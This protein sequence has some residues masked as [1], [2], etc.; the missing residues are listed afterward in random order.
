MQ[1]KYYL[2]LGVV[3]IILISG[4]VLV[5]NFSRIGAVPLSGWLFK[6]D[7]DQ[8]FFVDDFAYKNSSFD[9]LISTKLV[10]TE[11]Q[12]KEITDLSDIYPVTKALS[13]TA[14]EA[15]KIAEDYIKDVLLNEPEPYINSDSFNRSNDE[16]PTTLKTLGGDELE[17][18]KSVWKASQSCWKSITVGK[19]K[20]LLYGDNRKPLAW[21]V[22]VYKNDT[23]YGWLMTSDNSIGGGKTCCDGITKENAGCFMEESLYTS[24][25]SKNALLI[26]MQENN[27]KSSIIEEFAFQ[28]LAKNLEV[29]WKY[30]GHTPP[31]S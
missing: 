27:I 6:L 25:K 17:Y 20:Y 16:I 1:R 30:S 10:L 11:S 24:E 21:F 29:L 26:Y 8:L 3:A 15:Q 14:E 19:P 13:V 18:E 12:V 4:L 7:N 22:P 28:Y 31:S 2:V 23:Y 5:D 9:R